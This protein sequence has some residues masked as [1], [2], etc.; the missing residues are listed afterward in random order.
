MMR[1]SKVDKKLLINFVS[2]LVA[3]VLSFVVGGIFILFIDKNPFQVFRILING[4]FTNFYGIGQVL[5]YATPLIFTGL[6]VAFAFKAGLFNIGCEGQIYIGAIICAWL[7]FV[8]KGL[9]PILLLPICILGAM[10][11]GAFWGFI[12]GLLKI[13]TGAH[14]VITTIMLNFIALALTN[15]IVSELFFVP[16]TIRTP[17]IGEGAYI[18]RIQELLPIFK[19]SPVNLSFF[20]AI[21]TAVIIWYLINHTR[22]GYEIKAV[23]YNKDASVYAGINI[24]RKILL[25]MIISGA[26]SGMVGLNFVLGYKHYFEQGFA[27][28]AGF[29]G[30]AVALL[31]KNNPIVLILTAL[32]FGFLTFGGLL[33]NPIVPKELVEILQAIIIL[34]VVIGNTIFS[35]VIINRMKI[36]D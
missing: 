27:G 31:A 13:K 20:I 6:S 35:R 19:G 18:A 28:G 22:I 10:I 33:I 17:V 34:F 16:G 21:F 30:I 9:H 8:M 3:L 23:G 14:E 24:S 4:T 29:V 15:Y 5:F 12:P 36:N 11:G 2:P 32:L 26:L 1:K 25:T 7:G